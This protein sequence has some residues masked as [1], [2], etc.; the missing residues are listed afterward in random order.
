MPCLKDAG[1]K[2]DRDEAGVQVGDA[3]R[4]WDGYSSRFDL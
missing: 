1:S 2:E 4:T 3:V